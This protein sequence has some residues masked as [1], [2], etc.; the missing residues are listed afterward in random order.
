MRREVTKDFLS[1]VI[2][3]LAGGFLYSNQA[4][5]VVVLKRDYMFLIDP[6]SAPQVGETK[7]PAEI[8]MLLNEYQPLQLGVYAN[9]SDLKN[10]RVEV[11]PVD[12]TTVE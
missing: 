12:G 3:L 10:V 1:S 2:T 11:E 4:Q 8:R 5:P 7:F 9:G 6:R